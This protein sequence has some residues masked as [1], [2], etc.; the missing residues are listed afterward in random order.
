MGAGGLGTHETPELATFRAEVRAWLEQHVPRGWEPRLAGATPEEYVAFHRSWVRTLRDGGYLVPHWPAEHGGGGNTV[1]EQIVIQQEMARAKAPELRVHMISLNH[2][3]A[4]L[5][6]HGT[7]EQRRLLPGILD[8]DIWCQGFS[9]PNAGSDLASLQT[10]AVRDGDHYV[11]NGQKIW[12]SMANHAQWCLLLARTDPDAPKRK[13]ISYFMLDLS[14]PGLDI[15]PIRQATGDAEFCEIFFTDVHIPVENRFGEEGEGWHIAQT[16]L[17][18]ER[19]SA[20]IEL[21]ERLVEALDRLCDE[22][23]ST[24]TG[25]GPGVSGPGDAGPGDPEGR[26]VADDAAFRDELG[27]C[28][29]EVEILGLLAARMFRNLLGRGNL[30]PEASIVKL[31]YSELLQRLTALGVRARGLPAFVDRGRGFASSWT[32]GD[33]LMDHIG[34]WT[35]TIAGGTNEIQRNVIGERVLGLPR[36]PAAEI[37]PTR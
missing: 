32:S 4:T 8:G 15:R 19:G 5:M 14:T 13:G 30:G 6:E 23:V 10:R 3:G 29:A 22:A 25:S 21:Q 17:T 27:R 33:W 20:I 26:V 7:P 37:T 36:E 12:S 16:T 2:A 28:A 24:P 11:V 18:N 34:S 31:F 9:E 1:A 35:W